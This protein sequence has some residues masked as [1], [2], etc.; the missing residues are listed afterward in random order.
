MPAISVIT[1]AYNRPQPLERALRSVQ[2]Q[3]FRDFEIIVVDDGS[4]DDLLT[5]VPALHHPQVRYFRQTNQGASAARNTGLAAAQGEYISFL[6]SDDLFLPQN[7]EW[8]H[9]ALAAEPQAGIAHG[10]ATTVDHAGVETQWTRPRLTG[11]AYRQYLFSNPNLMGTLLAR[12]A[13]F[14]HG[15]MFDISLPVFEDWDLWLRLSFHH[16]FVCVPRPVARVVF[17]PVQRTTSQPARVIGQT[18]RRI[19]DNLYLDP[20]AAPIAKPLAR[21]LAANVHV[22]V[23]HQY[24]LFERDLAAARREFVLALRCDPG[25]RPAHK[26]LLQSLMGLR[27]T[28]WLRKLRSGWYARS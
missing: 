15:H 11:R 1:P 24:R 5:L 20:A 3:S 16:A 12:R 23:G 14:S 21:Q 6:D 28:T 4:T 2:A 19:Y 7:L 13:C 22:M 9:A 8:L 10:W 25:F 26:G 18:V 27:V 17:Q